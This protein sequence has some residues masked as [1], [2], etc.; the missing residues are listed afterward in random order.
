MQSAKKQLD[1]RIPLA[2]GMVLY[3]VMVLTDRAFLADA[4]LLRIVLVV[5]A[6][7]F[8]IWGAF[9]ARSQVAVLFDERFL[10][11]RLKSTRLAAIVGLVMIAGWFAYEAYAHQVYYWH[12]L[13][14]ATAMAVTKLAAMAYYRWTD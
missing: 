7:A 12:L 2:I 4:P 6:C 8:A 5:L 10:M 13:V 11:H 1:F 9:L 14:I 3:G